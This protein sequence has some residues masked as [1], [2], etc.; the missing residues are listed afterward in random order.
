MRMWTGCT[1][2]PPCCAG[3]PSFFC[4]PQPENRQAAV[5]LNSGFKCLGRG[6]SPRYRG[7]TERRTPREG[8]GGRRTRRCAKA[9]APPP[10]DQP[11]Y[12][13]AP[14][15]EPVFQV[16]LCSVH[17][18]T[19]TSTVR[20]PRSVGELCLRLA[21]TAEIYAMVV[22][23][24]VAPDSERCFSVFRQRAKPACC[25]NSV[26][27]VSRVSD[28]MLRCRL[29]GCLFPCRAFLVTERSVTPTSASRFRRTRKSVLFET[30]IGYALHVC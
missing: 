8:H 19:S 24:L 13:R 2:S 4:G 15:Q 17:I 6:Q 29:S 10:G 30:D 21:C 9:R 28:L 14:S 7:R 5:F 3:P 20:W 16:P 23:R 11:E 1:M 25:D 12:W 18:L 22:R 26:W 27:K